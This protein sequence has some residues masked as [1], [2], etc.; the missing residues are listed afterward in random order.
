[1]LDMTK[2]DIL[3]A[4]YA[5]AKSLGET[6]SLKQSVSAGISFMAEEKSLEK[7]SALADELYAAAE[8]LEAKLKAAEGMDDVNA[9]A[10]FYKDE[11][12]R[13]V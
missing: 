5:Y 13:C 11:V 3:P 12:I 6:I 1:M 9:C 4:V 8:V 2:K 10:L 7:V